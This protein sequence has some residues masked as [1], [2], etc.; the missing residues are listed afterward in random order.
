MNRPQQNHRLR[1]DSSH[2]HVEAYNKITGQIFALEA[3][4]SLS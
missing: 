2:N 4:T 3:Q 1:K